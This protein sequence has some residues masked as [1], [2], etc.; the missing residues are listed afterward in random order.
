MSGF[1]LSAPVQRP[2]PAFAAHRMPPPRPAVDQASP[3]GG[4]G[5]A[6]TSPAR[7][8]PASVVP[9]A[10]LPAA[11]SAAPSAVPAAIAPRALS[12]APSAAAP[13]AP[14]DAPSAAA[15]RAPSAPPSSAPPSGA[16]SA[17]LSASAPHGP[18][19]AVSPSAS[20]APSA[21][22][23]AAAARAPSDAP[24][25]ERARGRSPVS[26]QSAPAQLSLAQPSSPYRDTALAGQPGR[27]DGATAGQAL[28]AER[29]SARVPEA[30]SFGAASPLASAG[31][32]A[33]PADAAAS[34]AGTGAGPIDASKG[35]PT[36]EARTA[37]TASVPIPAPR[38]KDP[39]LAGPP[40]AFQTAL[41]DLTNDLDTLVRDMDAA[42]AAEARAL[43][44]A[45]PAA[46]PFDGPAA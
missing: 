25:L 1:A 13:R 2:Q 35:G 14:S 41:L 37:A 18:S 32:R 43:Y 5:P 12:A 6:S 9:S 3:R 28:V 36:G 16:R 21:A 42:R 44:G 15:R 10:A 7:S 33:R 29:A 22:P 38:I 45:A 31:A 34:H 20:R 17:A 23:S 46:R 39:S 8:R 40:P 30:P 11:P 26:S 24:S 4:A 27:P 19:A